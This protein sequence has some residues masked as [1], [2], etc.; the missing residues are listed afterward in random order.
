MRED[1]IHQSP[2]RVGAGFLIR[3]YE[4][5]IFLIYILQDK[6]LSLTCCRKTKPD[7]TIMKKQL[8]DAPAFWCLP[9]AGA[10]CLMPISPQ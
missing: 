1:S 2:W 8:Y 3:T 6:K 7:M 10:L 4:C 5:R 9:E